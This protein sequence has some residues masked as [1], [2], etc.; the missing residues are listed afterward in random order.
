MLTMCLL[1]G[2]RDGEKHMIQNVFM[3]KAETGCRVCES[4]CVREGREMD[5]GSVN[6]D[7]LLVSV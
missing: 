7:C 4:V 6:Q 5:G 3:Q 1:V 2:S